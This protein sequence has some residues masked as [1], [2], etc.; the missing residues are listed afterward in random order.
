[1][2]AIAWEDRRQGTQVYASISGDGGAT[3]AAPVRASSETGD[4]IAGAA[5]V[6]QIAAAGSGVLAVVYQ[7][8]QTGS[9][10]HSFVATSID[11]GATWTFT[12]F[13]LDGGAGAA[14]L[15]QIVA[16]QVS[17]KPA[18]VAAWTDFR[19]NQIDGDIYVAVSH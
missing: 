18:A 14:I 10:L 11:T 5:T 1:M 12:E 13:R 3:F 19:A 8:Q 15:P 6:P 17:G 16:S 9:R 7:N 4:P 2:V